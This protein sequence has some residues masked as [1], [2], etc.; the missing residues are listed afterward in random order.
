MTNFNLDVRKQY[1]TTE[2]T[3][4]NLKRKNTRKTNTILHGLRD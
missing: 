2:L 4:G 1:S 3:E